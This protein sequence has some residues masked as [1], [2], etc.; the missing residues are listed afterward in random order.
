MSLRGTTPFNKTFFGG[1][2]T[3]PDP[4]SI[5]ERGAI[6]AQNIRYFNKQIAS[7]YGW[8]A[9][10]SLG[11]QPASTGYYSL[12]GWLSSL[13]NYLVWYNPLVGANSG[14]HAVLVSAN[15]PV[16]ILISHPVVAGYLST[17]ATVGP[18]LYQAYWALSATADMAPIST[19]YAITKSGGNFNSD[20]I[21]PG[22][23][24][25]T[26]VPGG[27]ITEPSGGVVSA[28][29]HKLGYRMQHR[30]GFLGRMSPDSSTSSNPTT[31]SFV[32][33]TFTSSGNK[34]LVWSFTPTGNWPADV[35]Q[36]QLVM[37]PVNSPNQFYNV[38]GVVQNV[39]GGAAT[40][41]TFT[42]NIDDST[43]T[44]S[45]ATIEATDSLT[46][47]TAS[48]TGNAYMQV[49]AVV[50]IATRMFYVSTLLDTNSN[51]FSVVFASDPELYQQ[52][53][54]SQHA[55]QLPNQL[56]ITTV[57]GVLGAV[58]IV[59]P[60]WT[61]FTVDSG[62]VPADWPSPKIVDG[63]RGALYP[64]C[65]EVNAQGLY[66]WVA[67]QTGLY[68]FNGAYSQLPI[69]WLNSDIWAQIKI[70][71]RT[72]VIKDDPLRHRVMVHAYRSDLAAVKVHVWD[73]TYGMEPE[74]VRYSEQDP[75]GSGSMTIVQNDL[76]S[77]AGIGNSLK[78]SEV[79]FSPSGPSGS[80]AFFAREKN[81]AFDGNVYRDDFAG[82][83]TPVH[84]IY[85]TNVL[86][87]P[88]GSPSIL[89]HQA[90][91]PRI[92]GN[93]SM[94][95]WKVYSL[96]KQKSKLLPTFSLSNTPDSRVLQR[97]YLKSNGFIIHFELN[98]QDG[99]FILS[100]LTMYYTRYASHR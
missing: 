20:S 30:S 85:E 81:P 49:T 41:V 43:L 4:P 26:F 93:G 14:I 35:V 24:P 47:Y 75:P 21:I 5:D 79:W 68:Y 69:S 71:D 73:Y 61:Y 29:L 66:A 70:S 76:N 42:I 55:I 64:N 15:P 18:R 65:V 57:F 11:T 91:F 88:G 52:I 96:D 31:T 60:H 87:D 8:G 7:R 12:F 82:G 78:A 74:N 99:F 38:P 45:A 25:T 77:F 32:P 1:A 84:A 72:F 33:L 10:F 97:A 56:A 34:N 40:P 19:A 36:V 80:T 54:V 6:L 39:T 83:T 22:P 46:W 58:Y 51:A 98:V 89:A 50:N 27:G 95:L 59:G 17:Y 3:A 92:V 16:D 63:Q 94:S 100:D 28:G 9:A 2:Q 67:D 44:A 53:T 23:S 62:Q 37:S 90:L 86:P 48:A 13:G